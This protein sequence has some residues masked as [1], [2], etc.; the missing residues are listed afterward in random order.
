MH[1]YFQYFIKEKTFKTKKKERYELEVFFPRKITF[2]SWKYNYMEF[3]S[4]FSQQD[5][6]QTLSWTKFM[7]LLSSTK[8]CAQSGRS[9]SSMHFLSVRGLR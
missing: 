2:L 3:C 5:S 9:D 4:Y 7:I 1:I 8:Q 6:L